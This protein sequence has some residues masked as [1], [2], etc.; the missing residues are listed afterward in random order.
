MAGGAAS[1]P[2]YRQ[3]QVVEVVVVGLHQQDLA[4]GAYGRDHVD[5]QADLAPP[6]GIRGGIRARA[7]V[8][9]HLAEAPVGSGAR[10]QAE[11]RSVGTEVGLRGR[12]VVGVDNRDGPA[13]TCGARRKRVG[14]LQVGGGVCAP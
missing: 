2:V 8:L 9:V 5:V 3:A 6:A 1:G 4:G 14:G 12:Q 10:G 7:A 11:L 13:G